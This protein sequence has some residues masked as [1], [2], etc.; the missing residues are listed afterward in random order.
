MVNSIAA[1]FTL[2]AAM[3]IYTSGAWN[4]GHGPKVKALNRLAIEG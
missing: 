4:N 1:G 3:P 2:G